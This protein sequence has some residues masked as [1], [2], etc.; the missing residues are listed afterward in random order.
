MRRLALLFVKS[1]CQPVLLVA[2]N[3]IADG[4]CA[5]AGRLGDLRGAGALG[6]VEQ[7]EGAQDYADLLDAAF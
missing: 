1:S 5:E 4:L 2:A 7:G 3:Q 6:E